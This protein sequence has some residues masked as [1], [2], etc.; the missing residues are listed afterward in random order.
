MLIGGTAG[1]AAVY[2]FTLDATANLRQKDDTYGEFI[3]GACG[4]AALGVTSTF[5][6]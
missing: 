5:P 1:T 6:N 3:A 2:Q 4:G